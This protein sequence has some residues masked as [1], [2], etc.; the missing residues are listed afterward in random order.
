MVA[1]FVVGAPGAQ[2]D[3]VPMG[4]ARGFRGLVLT[5]FPTAFC[6]TGP[7][8]TTSRA[9]ACGWRG[10]VVAPSAL[11]KTA[12]Q[13]CV[14]RLPVVHLQPRGGDANPQVHR[15]QS[16]VGAP[17]GRYGLPTPPFTKQM[18]NLLFLFAGRIVKSQ[19]EHPEATVQ[20]H[21]VVMDRGSWKDG[22]V[23]R[24][25]LPDATDRTCQECRPAP[26][27]ESQYL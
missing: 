27:A 8:G 14:A 17:C 10:W 22:G 26:V 16:L 6:A 25:Q 19:I 18:H 5:I 9:W 7:S 13:G 2:K 20:T 23:R 24:P 12:P 11:P 15:A 1:F 4:G 21:Y 3:R